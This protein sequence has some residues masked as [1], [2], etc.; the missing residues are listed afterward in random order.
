MGVAFDDLLPEQQAVADSH[1]Q[2]LLVLG[3]AGVGK[4]TTALWAARRQLTNQGALDRSS[5]GSRVLFVT[6]SRTAVNQ[7]KARAGGVL[8]GIADAVEIMTFHGLAYRL[9]RAFGH[10]LCLPPDLG[11]AGEARTKIL[12]GSAGSIGYD[13]LIPAALRL[14]ECPT[15]ISEVLLSRWQLVICDEFQDTDDLEWRLLEHLGTTA[16]LLLLADPNQMIYP[17]KKG[18]NAARLDAARA[19]DGAFEVALPPGSH[20]DPSQVIP[21]AA[22]AIRVR[23]F[24]ADI[25]QRAVTEGRLLVHSDVPEDDDGRAQAIATEVERLRGNGQRSFGIYAKTNNDAA[26]LSAALTE[27]GLDHVPIGFTEAFGEALTAMLDMAAYRFGHVSWGAVRTGLACMLTASVR[28]TKAP[29]LAVALH[30]GGKLPGA[31][32]SRLDAIR[33]SLEAAPDLAAAAQVALVAWADL[34]VTAGQRAWRRAGAVFGSLVGRAAL[35]GGDAGALDRV[36]KEVTGLR[37]LSFVDLDAGDAGDVQLMN[38]SQT[39]GREADAALLSYTSADYY[40]PAGEPFDEASR[41]LYVS[42]TRARNIV[43][44]FLPSDPHPLVAPFLRYA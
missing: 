26:V 8:H 15:V 11:L 41:V 17:F 1:H 40:G 19:R 24:T 23:D 28:S 12:G 43:V 10:V 30:T 32:E 18:V 35:V 27:R 5:P 22:A 34:N 6:F 33:E 39:K 2:T 25:V 38:F 31:L 7:I 42:M 4:T 44:V 29:D 21:D 37:T 16:Q 13:E 14:L 36:A 9:I 20:R 3:G